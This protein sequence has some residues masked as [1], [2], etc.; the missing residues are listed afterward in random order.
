[1][2]AKQ[3]L[4][5][6]WYETE[7]FR[8]CCAA[9]FCLVVA[10]KAVQSIFLKDND[11]AWHMDL[12]RSVLLGTPYVSP[13]GYVFG[14]HYPPGRALIDAGLALL[15]Y[16]L[17]RTICF[18]SAMGALFVVSRIWRELGDAMQPASSGLHFAAA[19]FAFALLAPWVVRDFDECGLQI[20]LLLFIS[21]S[22]WLVWRGARI[23]AAAWLALAITWKSTPLIFVPLLLWKRRWVEAA[24]TIGFVLAFN[25][26][27][28]A[29][30]W[31]PTTAQQAL[32]RYIDKARMVATLQDPAENGVEPPTHRNQ[33]LPFAIARYL[34]TYPP[35]HPLFINA[36][37]DHKC[38]PKDIPNNCR[39]DPLFIQ[40]LDLP[41]ATAKRVI[42]VVLSIFSLALAWRMRRSWSLANNPAISGSLSA[43]APEW[44]A[45]CA[46]AALFA[47]LTWHQHLTLALP[48]AYI[49][50]RQTMISPSRLRL[51]GLGVVFLVTWIFHRDPLSVRLSIIVMSYHDDVLAV[52]ILIAMTL[53]TTLG[54]KSVP[55]LVH[56]EAI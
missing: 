49:A 55:N 20:L 23:T 6:A 37:F 14:T 50:I 52:L 19:L 56:A 26:V 24:A 40:F 30:F 31:G 48:C 45:T 46:L 15:P 35:G 4:D 16:R 54:I 17:A 3:E 28:P 27:V 38:E 18:A 12:G 13:A 8:W 10:I 22:G 21:M 39:A 44:A 36:D 47:P 51:L 53:R 9:V 43:L 11:F 2:T 42:T 7:R 1:V 32:T 34:Q 5:I 25:V 41:A 29:I 33:N